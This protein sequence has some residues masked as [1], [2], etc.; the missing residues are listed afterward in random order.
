MQNLELLK[1]QL[2]GSLEREEE[3]KAHLVDKD[4]R[5][6]KSAERI[7]NLIAELEEITYV[8]F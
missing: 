8:I 6:N 4:Q 2:S 5:L 1:I 7:K 3:L